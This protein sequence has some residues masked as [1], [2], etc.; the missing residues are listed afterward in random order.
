MAE[1]RRASTNNRLYERL[2]ITKHRLGR[3][4]CHVELVKELYMKRWKNNDWD[5]DEERDATEFLEL[6]KEI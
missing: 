1:P 5:E 3:I 2:V 4:Y 6:E